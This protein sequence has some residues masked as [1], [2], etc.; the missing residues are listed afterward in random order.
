MYEIKNWKKFQH[1]G[2]RESVPWIKLHID[3]LQSELWITLDDASR[4]LAVVCM[5][6]ASKNKGQVVWSLDTLKEY[7]RIKSKVSFKPLI[8]IGFL[9]PLA[10]AS[11]NLANANDS[12]SYSLSDSE[13]VKKEK[14]KK[15]SLE[16]L[17]VEHIADWLNEK[18]MSGKYINHDEF[19]IL[20]RFKNY[21]LSKGK[22]YSDYPAALRNAFEW[23][24]N[25][26]KGI[27]N[28]IMDTSTRNGYNSGGQGRPETNIQ[29]PRSHNGAIGSSSIHT[30]SKA[31]SEYRKQVLA[32]VIQRREQA[33]RDAELASGVET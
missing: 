14:M 5:L 11:N 23:E 24:S 3:L 7:G 22:R 30:G 4:L 28:G 2:D 26:P 32:D 19:Q 10:N 20:E 9:I 8:D 27:T 21:C 18:R 6:H 31:A 29:Q 33:R 15:V 25:Q 1:Y 17:S 12:L 16:D 13:S